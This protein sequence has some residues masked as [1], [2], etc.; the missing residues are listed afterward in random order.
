MRKLIFIIVIAFAGLPLV[1]AQDVDVSHVCPEFKSALETPSPRTVAVVDF[2]TF[3]GEVTELGR[4]LAE[5]FSIA[6]TNCKGAY[7]VVDRTYVSRILREHAT[8][9][10]TSDA[11]A[12]KQVGKLAGADTLLTGS[13]AL[14]AETVRVFVKAIDANSTRILTATT[15][16]MPKTRSMVDISNT[17]VPTQPPQPPGP[18]VQSPPPIGNLQPA[19]LKT[20][21]EVWRN[22]ANNNLYKF[23]FDSE[24]LIIYELHSN[25]IVADLALRHDKKDRSKDKYVGTTSLSRCNRG[26]IEVLSWS[27]TRIEARVEVPDAQNT[28]NQPNLFFRIHTWTQASFIPEEPSR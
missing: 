3:S 13:Y 14:L 26:Q 22:V 4:I 23:R 6:L 1:Y 11:Q 12:L 17:L 24:H 9:A 28:C 25:Q 18:G 10:N 16:E 27:P 8:F 7:S 20:L 5:E 2:T 15:L 21:P 19:R